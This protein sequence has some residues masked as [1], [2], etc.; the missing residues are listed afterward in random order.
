MTLFQV[1]FQGNIYD[2]CDFCIRQDLKAQ[3]LIP[4]TLSSFVIKRVTKDLLPEF[5]KCHY[6]ESCITFN[7]TFWFECEEDRCLF[8]L[9]MGSQAIVSEKFMDRIEL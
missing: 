8:L 3:A 1:S 7:T 6:H 9:A 4:E 5:E 2:A